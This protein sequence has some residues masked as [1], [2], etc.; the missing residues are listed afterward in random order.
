MP[1][2]TT[3]PRVSIILHTAGWWPS[4]IRIRCVWPAWRSTIVGKRSESCMRHD[5]D[6]TH[7]FLKYGAVKFNRMDRS[8]HCALVHPQVY[9]LQFSLITRAPCVIAATR[10]FRAGS[11][12]SANTC[13]KQTASA[14]KSKTSTQ[15]GDTTT[16]TLSDPRFPRTSH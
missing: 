8:I 1:C 16:S 14:I 9:V 10:V 12:E 6:Y 4:C 15:H 3:A 7:F 5:P 13:I 11:P 2:N